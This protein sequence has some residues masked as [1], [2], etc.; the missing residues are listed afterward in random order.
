M[1]TTKLHGIR[2][3]LNKSI[4]YI[5]DPR[6][7]RNG[8]LVISNGCSTSGQTAQTEFENV[9]KQGSGRSKILA[10]H[11]IQSF[12]PGEITPE[13]AQ[14]VG[15]E[16]CQKL[17]GENYQYILAT[18]V[19]HEH[20]HNHIIVNNTNSNTHNTFETEFNQGKKSERAWA[21]VRELSD[22]ICKKY[23][24]S[25]IQNPE[26]N[27]GKTHYEWDMSRQGL[28]WKAKLKF[29][30]DNAIKESEDFEDFLRVCKERGIEVVYNPEH[31]I[32]LKFK[33][34]GQK[35]FTRSRTLGWYYETKQIIKR[36]ELYNGIIRTNEKSNLIDTQ[37]KKIQNSPALQ[38]WAEIEN[39]KRTAKALNQL[40]EYT[41]KDRE[42]I[43]KK[44]FAAHTQIGFWVDKL[45]S[46]KTE[47]D[48]LDVK[49]KV[50]RKV[51]KLKPVID[52]L[53]TLSGREK[54][55]FESEHQAEIS[56]YR[57]SVKHLKE[58]FPSGNVPTP[59]TMEKKRNALAEE[60]SVKHDEYLSLKAKVSEFE[61]A[62]KT[63]NDFLR[64]EKTA[65]KKRK[66]EIGL[67]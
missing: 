14:V 44:L 30:I 47:I 24:L 2:S 25:V 59:E 42:S 63:V 60:R 29:A 34:T 1:A 12:A 62:R 13:E 46:L 8:S 32:D 27:R 41:E 50:A 61:K 49:I 66:K 65:T 21:K 7:T 15:L 22:E 56:D 3:T 51:Q 19:D 52:K 5:I 31:V 16:F 35:K 38:H 9:R 58:M 26:N 55:R 4:E 54:K 39:M 11:I 48:D 43:E 57:K 6:K 33:L 18:H 64:Q 67:F 28:S 53:N 23:C 10:Q 17:L 37:T 40:T 45:N 20:I 36:I